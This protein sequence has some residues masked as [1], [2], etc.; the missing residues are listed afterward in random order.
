[1]EMKKIRIWVNYEHEHVHDA[2]VM[3]ADCK[4]H[5]GGND[6]KSIYKFGEFDGER[7]T[8]RTTDTHTSDRTS[9]KEQIA[10][11]NFPWLFQSKQKSV[12]D[13]VR[14]FLY[15]IQIH[16]VRERREQ[17]QGAIA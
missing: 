4:Y 15:K 6:E 7:R 16:D 2:V 11:N 13:V 10:N 5:C 12:R 14:V 17:H 9:K 3:G 8:S 1:M